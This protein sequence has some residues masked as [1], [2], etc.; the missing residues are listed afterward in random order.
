MKNPELQSVPIETEA[1][2]STG[3]HVYNPPGLN[4]NFAHE[5]AAVGNPSVHFWVHSYSGNTN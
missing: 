3:I 2:F 4:M 1:A 5:A